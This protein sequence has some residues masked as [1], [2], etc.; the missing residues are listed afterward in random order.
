VSVSR[1]SVVGIVTRRDLDGQGI[2]SR[3]GARFSALVQTGHVAYQTSST[4]GNGFI[5]RGVKRSGLG[6]D[7]RPTSSAEVRERVE[8]YF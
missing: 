5:P 1:Y 7:Q 6:A 2:E 8:L 4:M 3:F